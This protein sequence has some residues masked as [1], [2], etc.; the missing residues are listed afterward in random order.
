MDVVLKR[1]D[2]NE[3]QTLGE[4]TLTHECETV[5]TCKTLELPWRNNEKTVSCIPK[6]TYKVTK[7]T[8]P[9]FGK[10]FYVHDVPGRSQILIH[11]GN[12]VRDTKGCIIPGDSFGDIDGDGLPDVKNSVKTMTIL[13]EILPSEFYLTIE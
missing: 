10:C 6:G 9:T 5:F 12:Y 8:S 4:M 1:T 11:R 2:E 13:L 3:K 7:H